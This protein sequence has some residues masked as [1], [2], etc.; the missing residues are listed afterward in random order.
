MLDILNPILYILFTI[1]YNTWQIERIKNEFQ[2]IKLRSQKESQEL[3]LNSKLDSLKEI[4]PI[5][6]NFN[7]AKVKWTLY[8]WNRYLFD[9]NRFFIL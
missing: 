4:F 6:D 2:A 1:Q 3:L 5:I 9:F 8:H 7:R